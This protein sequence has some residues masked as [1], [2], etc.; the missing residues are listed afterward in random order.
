[1]QARIVSLLVILALVILASGWWT[2]AGLLAVV[3]LAV[4]LA[5]GALRPVVN[6]RWCIPILLLIVPSAFWVGTPDM[7]WAGMKISR[8]GVDLGLQ[9][10]TRATAIFI[11]VNIFSQ[12]VSIM[13]LMAFMERFGMRGM[14][15]A[16]GVGFHALPAL[17]RCF[18]TT[19]HALR[20][21]GGFRQQRWRALQLLL[22]T[23]I[24]SALR[25]GEE[26][27]LAAEAR[28]FDHTKD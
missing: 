26:V 18:V 6:W 24:M 9:M 12:S 13:S 27:V 20:L 11:A 4:W 23:V 21:R 14:G 3:V 25:Y 5:P 22:I 8:T 16:I 7:F 17:K 1:M 19:Y 10:A 2:I 15:F 28:A